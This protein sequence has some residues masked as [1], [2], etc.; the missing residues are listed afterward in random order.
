MIPTGIFAVWSWALE[1]V[2]LEVVVSV[3]T[4]GRLCSAEEKQI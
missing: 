1:K 3:I 2:M 4:C